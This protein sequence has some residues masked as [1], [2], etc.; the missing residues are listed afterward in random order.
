MFHEGEERG[1]RYRVHREAQVL[2]LAVDAPYSAELA[3]RARDPGQVGGFVSAAVLAVKAKQVDDGLYAAVELATHSGA[4]MFRGKR[5]LIDELLARLTG[6][7]GGEA[8]ATLDAAASIGNERAASPGRAETVRAAFLADELRSKPIGFYTW[9]EALSRIFREDRLLQ[10]DIGSARDLARVAHALHG[11]PVLRA[12]YEACLRLPERL[13]NMLACADLR[14]AMSA[15]DAGRPVE[16]GKTTAFF[17]PSIAHETQ[18][19]K[20]LFGNSPIPDGFDLSKALIGAVRS[21]EIDLTP[22]ETSGWYDVQTWALEPLVAPERALEAK[23]LEL[24]PSYAAHLEELFRGI[25]TATRETHIKQLEMPLAGCAAPRVVKLFVRPHLTVEPLVTFYQRRADAYRFARAVLV[26]TF[27]EDGLAE[28]RGLRNGAPVQ[29]SL[30]AELTSMIHLFDGAA[31]TAMREL[32]MPTTWDTTAFES[33]RGGKGDPDVDADIRAMVPVFFD[34]AR[35]RTKVWMI[36]GWSRQTLRASF[37]KRPRIEVLDDAKAEI[38]LTSSWDPLPTPVMVE[39]YVSRILDRD[40]F[41]AHCDR[42]RTPD[43]IVGALA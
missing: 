10:S 25:L 36:L 35:R 19:V 2:R 21:G 9:S 12:S 6:D 42:F 33:W 29:Q 39:A 14:S 37:A 26:E 18:L 41:R 5:A 40:E 38:E 17:P 11:D 30:G 23:R 43:A 31:A 32:G 34:I 24:D 22:G 16:S 4:G 13:T 27:G 3:P 15:L 1:I 7:V 28:M 8:H 20:R